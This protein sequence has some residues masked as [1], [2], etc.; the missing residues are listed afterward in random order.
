VF[1]WKKVGIGGVGHRRIPCRSSNLASKVLASVSRI[2][3]SA[4]GEPF[5]ERVCASKEGKP[6]GNGEGAGDGV[7]SR[8]DLD[9]ISVA[10]RFKGG[11]HNPVSP[12]HSHISRFERSTLSQLTCRPCGISRPGAL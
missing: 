8:L 9:E 3:S 5:D 1:Y 10:C 12:R 4:G 2:V 7:L 6:L 11:P